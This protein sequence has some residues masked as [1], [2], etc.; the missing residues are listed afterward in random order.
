MGYDDIEAPQVVGL[1]DGWRVERFPNLETVPGCRRGLRAR[2][3]HRL[4]CRRALVGHVGPEDH[5]PDGTGRARTDSGVARGPTCHRLLHR[6]R[7]RLV[8]RHPF[9]DDPR[10]GAHQWPAPA[11]PGIASPDLSRRL[12]STAA[13]FRSRPWRRELAGPAAARTSFSAP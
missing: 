13:R 10:A 9:Q 2:V 6:Q 7:D 5:G 4:K 3:A 12:V 8:E 11:T 1:H